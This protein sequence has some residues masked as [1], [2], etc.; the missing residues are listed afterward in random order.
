VASQTTFHPRLILSSC[1]NKEEADRIAQALVEEGLAGCVS[2]VPGLESTYRWQSKIERSS[3]VLL[4]IKTDAAHAGQAGERLAAL[5]S[6][7][8]P[9]ILVLEIANGS[10][11]YLEWLGSALR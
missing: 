6:Y 5:H 11:G 9:E 4:L 10:K 2:I 8:V 7:E 1:A 3:E